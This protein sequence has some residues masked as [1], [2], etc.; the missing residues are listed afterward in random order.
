MLEADESMLG[1]GWEQ[2]ERRFGTGWEPIGSRLGVD[3]SKQ[4]EG[5]TNWIPQGNEYFVT[6]GIENQA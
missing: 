1:A 3:G 5:G 6:N 4:G 2:F